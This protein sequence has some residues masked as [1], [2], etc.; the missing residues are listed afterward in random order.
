MNL[1][2]DENISY[3]IV[4]TIGEEFP[5][6]K[7]V[8]EATPSL[9]SDLAIFNYAKQHNFI[10]VTFDEDFYELQLIRG[11][12]PKIVWLRTGNTSTLNIQ[13]KLM[14]KKQDILSL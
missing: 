10:I 7:H 9:K 5:G 2:F 11:F 14:D 13:R 1:L 8:T 4:K 12:P 3:R 6:C